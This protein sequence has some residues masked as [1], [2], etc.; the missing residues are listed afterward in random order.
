MTVLA[1]NSAGTA[2]SLELIL[3][4]REQRAARQAAALARFGK[5][6]VSM[7]VVMPGPVKDGALPRRLLAEAVR[8][9]DAVASARGWPVLS[10][11]VWWQETGPEAMHVIA[12][13]ARLLK[14]TT[15]EL[16][17]RHLLGRLWDLDVIA[18]GERPLSRKELNVPARRCL[19]CEGPAHDC[20]R[21]R[22]HSL[23]ELLNT[24]G[25]M[26]DAHDRRIYA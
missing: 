18:P 5:P 11:Q 14:A 2:V 21:S 10:R 7:T 8:K 19:V 16:E 9:L 17:D 4:A 6:M 24:I 3:A 23:E 12:A 26:V 25:K 13:E 15:V 1:P 22:R 20:A